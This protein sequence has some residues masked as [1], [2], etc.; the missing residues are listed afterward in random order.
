MLDEPNGLF[1]NEPSSYIEITKIANK[2]TSSGSPCPH[3][4]MS[5]TVLKRCPYI[6]ILLH[7]I[8]THCWQK[9]IFLEE[10]RYAF[11]LLIYKRASKKDPANF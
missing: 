6:R 4:Q 5:I 1:N 8:I 10:W 3:D 7:R 2:M 11:T 9:Q